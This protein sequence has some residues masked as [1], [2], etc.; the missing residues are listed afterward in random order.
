MEAISLQ[1][2]VAGETRLLY[3]HEEEKFGSVDTVDY[4]VDET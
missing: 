2:V 3:Y 1:T 4:C